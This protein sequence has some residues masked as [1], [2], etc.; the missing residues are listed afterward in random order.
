MMQ[1]AMDQVSG[2]WAVQFLLPH[3]LVCTATSTQGHIKAAEGIGSIYLL[4]WGQGVAVHYED[5]ARVWNL[6]RGG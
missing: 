1:E 5:A 4:H 6:R 2:A 3:A